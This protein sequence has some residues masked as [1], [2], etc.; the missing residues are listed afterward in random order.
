MRPVD[1]FVYFYGLTREYKLAFSFRSSVHS[2]LTTTVLISVKIELDSLKLEN[3]MVEKIIR[4]KKGIHP[5]KNGLL[6]TMQPALQRR[7]K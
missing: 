3:L 1:V 7:V 5:T 4:L 6:L 2:L